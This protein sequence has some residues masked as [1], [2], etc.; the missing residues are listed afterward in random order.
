[1]DVTRIPSK[2]WGREA[3]LLTD[4]SLSRGSLFELNTLKYSAYKSKK[5][6]RKKKWGGRKVKLSL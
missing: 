1:M 5:G 2:C 6:K 4:L 3:K